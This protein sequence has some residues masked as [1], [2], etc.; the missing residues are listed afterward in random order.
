MKDQQRGAATWSIYQ[1]L[2]ILKVSI[3][4]CVIW[5][6]GLFMNRL[7]CGLSSHFR[8]KGGNAVAWLPCCPGLEPG[9]FRLRSGSA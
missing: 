1:V 7:S 6:Q 9:T 2:F 4:S 5:H 8:E 3:D